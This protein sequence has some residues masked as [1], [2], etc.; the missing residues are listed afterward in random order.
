MI[1]HFDG[2]RQKQQ[3]YFAY[4]IRNKGEIIAQ[5]YGK[6]NGE[7]SNQAEYIALL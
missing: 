4:T 6:C 3:C 7:S 1:G 2:G 5:E